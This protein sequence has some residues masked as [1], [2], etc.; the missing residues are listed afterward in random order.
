MSLYV[1]KL[2]A[3]LF[4]SDDGRELVNKLNN[5]LKSLIYNDT[6]LIDAT[7]IAPQLWECKWIND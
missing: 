2:S 4:N 6:R 3:L 7:N 1:D 5:T